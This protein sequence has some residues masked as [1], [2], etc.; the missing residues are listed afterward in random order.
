MPY[1]GRQLIRMN[2]RFGNEAGRVPDPV[3]PALCQPAIQLATLEKRHLVI[4][5]SYPN[6][7]IIP[8]RRDLELQMSRLA[9]EFGVGRQM[10]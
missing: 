7:V 1:Q 2:E 6:W 4:A 3:E 10:R 5:I 8:P 9:G